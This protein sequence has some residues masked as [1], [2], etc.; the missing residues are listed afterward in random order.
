[1]PGTIYESHIILLTLVTS[2]G[3]KQMIIAISQIRKVR[4]QESVAQGSPASE[5]GV[6]PNSLNGLCMWECAT[7]AKGREDE[8]R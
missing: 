4:F 5:R 6:Y 3:D 2:L 1:M 8:K 7:Q